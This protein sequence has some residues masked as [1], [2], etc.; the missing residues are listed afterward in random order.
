[1]DLR[2]TW[3]QSQGNGKEK[4]EDFL[5][6][7]GLDHSSTHPLHHLR[8]NMFFGFIWA[9]LISL[10]YLVLMFVFPMW[11][12]IAGLA[13]VLAFNLYF[14]LRSYRLY[15]QLPA[16]LNGH[17]S[18]RQG[19]E[20]FYGAFMETNRLTMFAAKFVYPVAAAAGFMLGGVLG[21]GKS[22]ETLFQKPVFPLSMIGVAVLITPFALKLAARLTEAAYGKYLRQLKDHLDELVAMNVDPEQGLMG[23]E[24]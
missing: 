18:L 2:Q 22:L 13:V 15:R 24:G 14:M 4:L 10:G 11:P 9:V 17:N 19:L 12:I 7:K 8:R 6:G 23:T 20:Q 16:L 1:M 3:Q 5:P 21:S